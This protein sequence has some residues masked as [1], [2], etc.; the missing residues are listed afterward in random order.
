M[1]GLAVPKGRLVDQ[2]QYG[3]IRT[4][5]TESWSISNH[6][7]QSSGQTTKDFLEFLE[8]LQ[9]QCIQSF[10][11]IVECH[12]MAKAI[13]IGFNEVILSDLIL[14]RRWKGQLPTASLIYLSI[15]T[16]NAVIQNLPGQ[17]SDPLIEIARIL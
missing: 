1:S 4:I 2:Y 3:S 5:R 11:Q 16:R 9:W 8:F 15:V 10:N 14:V 13:L 12:W 6:V 7:F 17:I